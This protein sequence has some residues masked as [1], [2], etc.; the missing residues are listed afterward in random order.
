MELESGVVD[1]V[2]YY[3]P[4][5]VNTQLN[6]SPPLIPN[7]I[8]LVAGAGIP[9]PKRLE[10]IGGAMIRLVLGYKYPELDA[11]HDNY[12]REDA[13]NMPASIKKLAAGRVKYA[14]V[15][16]LSLEYQQKF[17]PEIASFGTLPITRI[18][19]GCGFSPASKIAFSE[20]DQAIKR[21]LSKDAVSHI[22]AKYR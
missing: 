12:Q 2:C 21:L 11:L 4:E 18:N 1:G 17:Q 5:W 3:R 10:E 8:L 9:T 6:W 19:A 14:V 22:L 16:R 7:D 20:L 15:D 13:P